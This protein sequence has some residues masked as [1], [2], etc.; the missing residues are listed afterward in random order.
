MEKIVLTT[1]WVHAIALLPEP[2]CLLQFKANLTNSTF[3]WIMASI[4]LVIAN[5]CQPA[6]FKNELLAS[7]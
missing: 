5:L 3:R 7:R 2:Q 4:S 6:M 1:E